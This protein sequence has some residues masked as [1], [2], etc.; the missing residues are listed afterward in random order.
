MF[1][2]LIKPVIVIN[3][4]MHNSL[5]K[6]NG[7]C[8]NL[9]DILHNPNFIY[10]VLS[11]CLVHGLFSAYTGKVF[12]IVSKYGLNSINNIKIWANIGGI[13]SSILIAYLIDKIKKVKCAL[14]SLIVVSLIYFTVITIL[15]SASLKGL[16]IDTIV[17]SC[18]YIIYYMS[19]SPIY[20]L[21][22]YLVYEITY[23]GYSST[24]IALMIGSS[25]LSSIG[26]SYVFDLV[27][28]GFIVHF[29]SIGIIL[30][31]LVLILLMNGNH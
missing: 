21:C 19:L 14:I 15:I 12:D 8:N 4:S 6:H 31:A 1:I 30:I 23:P 7:C 18:L 20:C 24:S 11:F 26:I 17:F 28:N 16:E 27:E 5:K 29:I 9:K 13:F 10:L 25:M 22:Y 2:T 3:M